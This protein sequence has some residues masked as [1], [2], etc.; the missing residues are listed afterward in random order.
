MVLP[1]GALGILHGGTGIIHGMGQACIIG[2]THGTP[3]R[4]G[5][6]TTLG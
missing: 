5:H 4:I 2:M 3:V 6:G 1:G